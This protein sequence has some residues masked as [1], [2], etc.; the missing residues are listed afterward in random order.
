MR[1]RTTYYSDYGFLNQ[2]E[3]L[4]KKW[5]RSIDF[6]EE[7][8]LLE[9]AKKVNHRICNEI[10]YSIVKGVS[11]ERLDQKN[12]VDCGK[13]DFYGYQRKTLATFKEALIKCGRYPFKGVPLKFY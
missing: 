13:G 6:S 3:N 11:F 10:Y 8:L 12:Y 4:L 9:C 5:C 7:T 1:T 2:E